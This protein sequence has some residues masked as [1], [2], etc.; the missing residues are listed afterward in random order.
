[1][2]RRNLKIQVIDA[3]RV[4]RCPPEADKHGLWMG[5]RFDNLRPKISCLLGSGRTWELLLK[6]ELEAYY[7]TKNG[8]RALSHPG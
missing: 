5:G 8:I 2:S 6:S 1:M 7:K 4:W 3:H